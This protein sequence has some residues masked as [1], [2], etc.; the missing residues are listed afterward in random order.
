MNQY[1]TQR[2]VNPEDIKSVNVMT[3]RLRALVKAWEDSSPLVTADSSRLFTEG[4]LANDGKNK[5]IRWAEA[6]AHRFRNTPVVIWDDELIV[7]CQTK[8]RKGVDVITAFMPLGIRDQLKKKK[9]ARHMS[10]G[11]AAEIDAQDEEDLLKDAEYWSEHLMPEFELDAIREALG[12]EHLYLLDDEATIIEGNFPKA[13]PLRA[14]VPGMFCST[15]DPHRAVMNTGLR[16]IIRQTQAAIDDLMENGAREGITSDAGYRK[17]ILWRSMIIFA[18]AI[19][20]WAQRY[21]DLAAEMAAKE[22]RPERKREL[23]KIADVCAHVPAE[24]PRDYWEALQSMRFIHLALLMELPQRPNVTI[25]RLDQYLYPYY[26]KDLDEGRLTRQQAAE[27]LGCFWLKVRQGEIVPIEAP[28]REN[29]ATPGSQLIHITIGGRDE[30]GRDVTN[31]VSWLILE[32]MRQML[33]SEPSIYVRYHPEMDENFLI[34][35]LECNRDFRGGNPSF[36]NDTLGTNRN[37]NHGAKLEDAVDWFASGCIGYNLESV[38]R[39]SGAENLNDMKIF[40]LA[41]NNGYDHRMKMQLGLKTGEPEDFHSLEDVKQAFLKQFDYFAGQMRKDLFIR[42]SVNILNCPRSGLGSLMHF[43]QSIETGLAQYEGGAKY[44]EFQQWW[45]G[46]RG[47]VDIA[48]SL[49]AIKKVVF[50]DKKVTLRELVDIMNRNWEGHEDLRRTCLNVVKFGNDDEYVD[51][52]YNEMLL[53]TQSIL[54]RRPDPFTGFKPFLYKGAA[55]GHIIQGEV[56]GASPN[57]RCAW[58]PLADG[59]TSAMHGMDVN[60]PSALINSATGIVNAWEYA[61][62][63]HNMKFPVGMM[64]NPEKLKKVLALMREYFARGGWN[65][66]FNILDSEELQEARVHPEQYKHVVVRVSGFCAYFVDLPDS[67]QDEIIGRTMH[68]I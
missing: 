31:E 20:D 7:G 55:R 29:G 62:C 10:A 63:I 48:D 39:S 65:I 43:E 59:G 42:R 50:E 67:L 36:M 23:E 27:L 15:P 19:I 21:S 2:P 35:A 49:A 5:D 22:T 38:E 40:E 41:L 51:S 44:P 53:A 26:E 56:C 13:H 28:K 25:G 33:L 60:G 37:L 58:E 34:Y 6:Q 30:M 9:M 14:G 57:G 24:P 68:S 18:E 4:W 17:L 46:D 3:D 11:T 1:N 52:I 12:E 47:I 66:Q 61:G 32:V 64:Q 8:Y 45:V 54:Q 16:E